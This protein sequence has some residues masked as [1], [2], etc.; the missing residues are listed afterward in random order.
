V[1]QLG[2]GARL[3][4]GDANLGIEPQDVLLLVGVVGLVAGGQEQTE[5]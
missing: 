4:Q 2:A 3:Q 1:D 5:L